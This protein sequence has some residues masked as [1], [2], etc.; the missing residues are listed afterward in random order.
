MFC[1]GRPRLKA[2][3]FHPFH[4]DKKPNYRTKHKSS[5]RISVSRLNKSSRFAILLNLAAVVFRKVARIDPEKP[6]FVSSEIEMHKIK[7][8]WVNEGHRHRRRR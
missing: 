4:P 5:S 1:K 2:K 3:V 7:S 8:D 6:E